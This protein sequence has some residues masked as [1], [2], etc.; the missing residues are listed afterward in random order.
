MAPSFIS[1][2]AVEKLAARKS[3]SSPTR[4]LTDVNSSVEEESKYNLKA[5]KKKRVPKKGDVVGALG[6]K[7]TF[8]VTNVNAGN[9][10]VD[11]RSLEKR[12]VPAETLEGVPWNALVYLPPEKSPP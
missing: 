1:R 6:H 5:M 9:R 12:N 4:N 7:G 3:I 11:L 10:S 2:T 8:E